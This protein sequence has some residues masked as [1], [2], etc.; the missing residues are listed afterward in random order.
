MVR[1]MEQT[2]WKNKYMAMSVSN[3]GILN[4]VLFIQ[5]KITLAIETNLTQ[6]L[7][8]LYDNNTVSP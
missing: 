4:P 7:S 6:Q 3:C 1:E 2:R 8:N 5:P